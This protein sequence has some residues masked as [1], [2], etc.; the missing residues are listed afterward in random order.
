MFIFITKQTRPSKD[1]DF[2]TPKKLNEMDKDYSTYFNDNYVVTEKFLHAYSEMSESGLELTTTAIWE[3]K[4]YA[5][6]FKN[7]PVVVE[8]FIKVKSRY[9]EENNIKSEISSEE[10]V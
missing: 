9:F 6:E 8:R 3:D 4:N 5:E 2:F 7:D 10:T 1:V